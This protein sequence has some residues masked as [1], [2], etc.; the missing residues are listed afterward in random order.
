MRHHSVATIDS[1]QFINL[2]PLD[3][4][5]L[6]S[7]CE[8]K[9]LY[10]G[11][12]RNKSFI[13]K[14]VAIQMSKTLR[15]SPIVGYYK[16][17]IQDF[18]D[19]GRSIII[20][21]QGIKF[22]CK[23]VPYGFVAPDAKVWFQTFNE[24]DKTGNPVVRQYLM[25]TGYLW[26]GQFEECKLA[27][28]DG[29]GQSMELDEN[30]LQGNWTTDSKTGMEFFIIN[31]AVFSKL[32]ILGQGVEPCFEGAAVTAPTISTNFSKDDDF[33]NTLFT[34]MQDLKTVI[35]KGGAQPM[36]DNTVVEEVVEQVTEDTTPAAEESTNSVDTSMTSEFKKNEDEEKRKKL[37]RKG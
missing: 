35:E 10:V 24:E 12:N 36:T 37:Q 8:V 34:M 16:Q 21:D 15:G 30:S 4:N 6:M 25:T 20:D 26:T 3:L 2:Q 1:P 7:S 29:R 33:A 22:E 32:C 17:E 5:P 28:T 9:V 13:S 18:A 11:E 19:H 14:Q 27:A 31:D 23:T